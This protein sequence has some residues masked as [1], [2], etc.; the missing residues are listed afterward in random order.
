MDDAAALI[1]D[2]QT[3]LLEY[4]VTN[5]RT[6]LFVL[7]RNST[8]PARVAIKVYPVSARR[9]DLANLVEDFRKLLAA[10]HPGFRRRGGELYDMLVRPVEQHLRGKTTLCIV[11]DGPLWELPF[12]ALQTPADKYLQE[13]HAMYY[14][15]SLQVLREMKKRAADLKSSPVSKDSRAESG[16]ASQL[17]AIGNP[18]IGDEALARTQAVRNAPFVS[19]PETER[20]VQTIGTEVYGPTASNI[21]VGSAAREET[22]KAEMGKY[23]V[24]HFATHGVRND[25]SPMYS[26]L[27][28]ATGENSNED[29]LLEAWELMEMDMKAEMVV[30][31]ACDT[32]R[33]HVGTGEGMIGMTWALFVA[34]VPTTVASQWKVPSETTPRLMVAFHKNAQ[35]MPKA[36]AWR[37]AALKMIR[38]PRFRMKPF[39]WAGFVVVGEGGM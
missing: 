3:A 9:S 20:E 21:H 34:G 12:Q 39:Y 5:E 14:A 18:T 32:A 6:F 15:P 27:V 8:R 19:L 11:P 4:V 37:E 25:R 28:L 13:L 22:V 38:D 1:P 10:N 23:R 26:Y 36:E 24:V 35:Q 29:G 31:S 17:Y 16:L 7:T 30:L 33:G 2:A